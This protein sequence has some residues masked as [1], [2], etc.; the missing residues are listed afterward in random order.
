MKKV[1]TS[2]KKRNTPGE[3]VSAFKKGAAAQSKRILDNFE[4]WEFYI[5]ESMDSDGMYVQLHLSSITVHCANRE[6]NDNYFA[7]R[8]VL[9]GYREDGIT[10]FVMYW[11]HG[12][13]EME[14]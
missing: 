12:L 6:N 11:K 8:V 7:Y 13:E 3:E 9:L 5:G 14:V 4:N 10:P 2:L 1:I